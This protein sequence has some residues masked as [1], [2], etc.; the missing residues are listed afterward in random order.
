MKRIA[1]SLVLVCLFG[2][3][4]VGSSLAK[5]DNLEKMPTFNEDPYRPT[6][7]VLGN[8]AHNTTTTQDVAELYGVD[9]ASEAEAD[10]GVPAADDDL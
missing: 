5:D 1:L 10:K 3:W 8:A 2:S 7:Q 4:S 9:T 6:S